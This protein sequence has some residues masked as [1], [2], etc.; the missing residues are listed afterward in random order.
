MVSGTEPAGGRRSYA[1]RSDILGG[2]IRCL[3]AVAGGLLPIPSGWGV[4]SAGAT[5][6]ASVDLEYAHG[7]FA[8][9]DPFGH[10]VGGSG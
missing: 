8:G 7:H 3:W 4:A 10:E 1:A 9:P 5:M 6:S 2:W